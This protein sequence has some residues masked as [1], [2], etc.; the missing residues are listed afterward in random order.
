MIRIAINDPISKP[1][2][3]KKFS[4][5]MKHKVLSDSLPLTMIDLSGKG[6]KNFRQGTVE[7]LA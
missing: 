3:L 1:D 5:A 6:L 7:I 2:L 4:S